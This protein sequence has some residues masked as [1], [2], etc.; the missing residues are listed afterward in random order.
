MTDKPLD[1]YG[2]MLQRVQRVGTDYIELHIV[3]REKERPD[4]PLGCSGD[5]EIFAGYGCPKHLLGLALDG[6]GMRGFVSDSTSNVSFI[7]HG[8]EFYDVYSSHERKLRRM[9]KAVKRVNDRI[10]KDEAREPG[11]Q[12]VA[13]AKALKLSFVVE[14]IGPARRDPDWRWMT[15]QEGRNRYRTLIDQAVAEAIARKTA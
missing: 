9:L 2:L 4:V 8:V 10:A 1:D 3:R 6:L 5:G 15:I 13:F 11:D 14:R 7:G 12:L